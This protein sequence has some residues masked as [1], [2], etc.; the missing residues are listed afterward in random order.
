MFKVQHV[1]G[2][3][4]E[5]GGAPL[6][7]QTSVGLDRKLAKSTKLFG[8]YTTGDIGGGSESNDYFGVG[9]EHKF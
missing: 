4:W 1:Q 3:I 7:A 9:I 2:D 6:E 8:F 5:I